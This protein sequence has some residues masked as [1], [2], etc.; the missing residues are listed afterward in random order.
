LIVATRVIFGNS[1][2]AVAGGL[3]LSVLMLPT[4]IKTTDEGLKL[5]PQELRWGSLGVG[6]SKFVTTM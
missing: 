3:A 6:A 5:V 1:Y 4:I 2:S